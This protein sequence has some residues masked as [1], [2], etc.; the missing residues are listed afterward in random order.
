[1]N[2]NNQKQIKELTIAYSEQLIKDLAP[3]EL[4]LI[5]PSVDIYLESEIG[6]S[7]LN[8]NT[9]SSDTF[10]GI[11][12]PELV[13]ALVIPLVIEIVKAVLPSIMEKRN[14][15]TKPAPKVALSDFKM[16]Y[17]ETTKELTIKMKGK[18]KKAAEAIL[19]KLYF[20]I[21]KELEG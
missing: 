3:E 20:V 17:N 7:N 8:A 21:L 2:N 16:I 13:T 5:E 6:I 14:T 4:G 10:M 1:V 19:N 15:K 18:N 9:N 12:S 11:G